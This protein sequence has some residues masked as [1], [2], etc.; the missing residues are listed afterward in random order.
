MYW[1]KI[2]GRAPM[3]THGMPLLYSIRIAVLSAFPPFRGGIAQ[4]DAS[5]CEALESEGH[6][7][8][9]VNFSP[10]YPSC[11]FQARSSASWF[12]KH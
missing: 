8:L 1:S 2:E 7:M 4:F 3:L 12:E 9:L 6:T 5:M 11:F 10:Q